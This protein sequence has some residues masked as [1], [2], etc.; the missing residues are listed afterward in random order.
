[1]HIYWLIYFH[2]KWNLFALSSEPSVKSQRSKAK[3]Y[4]IPLLR[5]L[6]VPRDKVTYSHCAFYTPLKGRRLT[7][8]GDLRESSESKE[9]K[10]SIRF[11]RPESNARSNI[12]SKE[13][14]AMTKTSMFPYNGNIGEKY[15]RDFQISRFFNQTYSYLINLTAIL[16]F[17]FVLLEQM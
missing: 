3:R 7:S 15:H 14:I 16:M 5:E 12:S 10:L 9:R 6:F 11:N 1:M 4:Q 2:L 13:W 8:M 17:A